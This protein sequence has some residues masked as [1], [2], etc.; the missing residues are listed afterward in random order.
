MKIIIARHG[1]QEKDINPKLTQKGK[2]QARQLAEKIKPFTEGVNNIQIFS[3]PLTRAQETASI[4][5]LSLG[6]IP[7]TTEKQLSELEVVFCSFWLN[8]KIKS[9]KECDVVIFITH[10]PNMTEY[11]LETSNT[12]YDFKHCEGVVIEDGLIRKI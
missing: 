11:L 10:H 5:S 6:N 1:E 7:I 2:E 12:V 8:E 4:V 9:F 3:S